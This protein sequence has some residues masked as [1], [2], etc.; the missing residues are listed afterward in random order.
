MSAVFGL[1]VKVWV[2]VLLRIKIY[3]LYVCVIVL[4]QGFYFLFIYL[5]F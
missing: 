4:K 5:L 1:L 2:L 3:D